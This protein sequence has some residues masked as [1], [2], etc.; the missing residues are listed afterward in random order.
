MFSDEEKKRFIETVSGHLGK[1]TVDEIKK[2]QIT[3]FREVSPD[4]AER[5]EKAMGIKGYDSIVGGF[6]VKRC[7]PDV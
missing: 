7:N 2:R 3:I 6:S 4:I 1:C 5:L